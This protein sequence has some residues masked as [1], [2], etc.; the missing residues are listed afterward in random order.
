[1]LRIIAH[2]EVSQ[3]HFSTWRSRAMGYSVS[4]FM[5]RNVLID[6]GF[7]HV[8]G[9]LRRWLGATRPAGVILTHAHED[10]AGN[11]EL[12]A[13]LGT[14]I[15]CAPETLEALRVP[16]PIG[17]YRRVCWGSATP[18][19]SAVRPFEDAALHLVPAR[20]HSPDHHVVWD[21]ERETVFGGDL[22]IGVKVRIAHPGEDIRGQL[23]ALRSVIALGPRRYFDAHRGLLEDPVAQLR[24]KV[25]WMEEMIGEIERH[26][27]AGW[28]ERA[29]R[30]AVLGPEDLTG[31]ASRGDYARINFVRGVLG[32]GG[33]GRQGPEAVA[34]AAVTKVT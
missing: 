7:P 4:A 28:D 19:R 25:A 29:I 9:A 32:S 1:M 31:W 26:A 21:P 6:T 2:G 3:L 17:W 15:R 5:T 33:T 22:F 10:H 16:R 11:A 13:R 12:L 30:D 8:A 23:P 20:G 18:L 24:A 14:S 27:D 34:T